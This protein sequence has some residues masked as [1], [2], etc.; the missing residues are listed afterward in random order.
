MAWN[1]RPRK[2]V[3]RMADRFRFDL[4]TVSRKPVRYYLAYGSNLDMERMGHRCPF[5]VPI[6]TTEIYG[7]RLLF[8]KSKTGSY[9]T[10]EQDAN[11]SVPA[12]VWQLSEYDELLLDRYEGCPRYY[13][14][15]Q[16]QLPV[17]NL[18]GHRMKK[19]KS[20]MAYILHEE[21]PLGCPSHDYFELLDDGYTEW[22]F[23]KDVLHRGLCASIGRQAATCFLEQTE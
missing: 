18:E 8:K 5:A 17:W 1:S 6:G 10:L 21:R 20:C 2:A 11:E 12:V 7:Y 13:Y 22:G 19:L 9:A 4:G 15:K 14:K 3:D 16:F 23:P